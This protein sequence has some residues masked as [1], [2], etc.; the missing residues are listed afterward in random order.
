MTALERVDYAD[1]EV[2]LTGLLARPAGIPRAA[3]LVF[4]TIMNVTP[5]VEAKALAL[6]E[7][8]Y[9]ALIADF[10]GAPVT[11]FPASMALAVALRADV[12]RY[13][14]RLGAGLAALAKA[15]PQLQKSRNR[16]L[17][18]RTG[19]AGTGAR[20]RRY[21]TRGQFSRHP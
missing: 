16:V 18:G 19:S 21:R 4:P 14:T 17:H 20:E 3:V 15:A 10:Y 9:I 12:D 8:G 7:Q 2:A 5:F 1:G 6:A 13:R 11:D